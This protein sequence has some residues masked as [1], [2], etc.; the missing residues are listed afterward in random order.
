M[1]FKDAPAIGGLSG[2]TNSTDIPGAPSG[3]TKSE[4]KKEKRK[5]FAFVE[6]SINVERV[7]RGITVTSKGKIKL[8]IVETIT[9]PP[10]DPLGESDT[11]TRQ[12]VSLF[13]DKPH[14]DLLDALKNLRE[15]GMILNDDDPTNTEQRKKYTVVGLD[16]RGSIELKQARVVMTLGKF[17]KRTE[18][19]N[20]T[21]LSEVTL[22]GQSE[23]ENA[24][25]LAQRVEHALDEA[26]EFMYGKFADT[27]PAQL[28][29][30]TR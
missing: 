28:G 11:T 13:D 12:H 5:P 7:V 17:I 25:R 22:Y 16:I 15:D 10:A 21:K 14:K 24:G 30:F 6:R 4:P 9:T 1:K 19:I 20:T 29:L 27:N 3:Q 23:Y 8:K 26:T 2:G 18:K